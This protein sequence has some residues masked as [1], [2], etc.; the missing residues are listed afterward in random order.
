MI[1]FTDYYFQNKSELDYNYV[2]KNEIL[3]ANRIEDL[4][5]DLPNTK[6]LVYPLNPMFYYN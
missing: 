6:I 2:Y 3:M 4:S 5:C 1:R